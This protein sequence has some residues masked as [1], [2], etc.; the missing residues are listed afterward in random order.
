MSFRLD[1]SGVLRSKR[2]TVDGAVRYDAVLT[3]TGVFTYGD[4]KKTWREYR[5]PSEVFDAESMAS[6]G[7]VPVTDDHPP[8]FVTSDN[9]NTYKKGRVGEDI[10][11]DGNNMVGSLIVDDAG[12]LGKM[13]NG[14]EE[15]SNGYECVVVWEAGVSPEGEKYDARQ[16]QIRGN[17]VAV[18]DRGRAGNAKVRADA[19]SMRTDCALQVDEETA[20]GGM[21][22]NGARNDAPNAV[23]RK[24][25]AMNLEQALA[26]LAQANKDNGALGV[27]L[28][29]AKSDAVSAEQKAKDTATALVKAEAERDSAKSRADGAE[30]KV[31]DA[32]TAATKAKTDAAA[33]TSDQ[34]KA[35]VA[36]YTKAAAVGVKEIKRTVDGKET[37]IGLLD[38][39]PREVQLAVISKI[40]GAEVP[41][42]KRDNDAYVDA[43]F[44]F[45]IEAHRKS[46][47][48]FDQLNAIVNPAAKT[49]EIAPKPTPSGAPSITEAEAR[50]QMI[51]DSA[52][53]HKTTEGTK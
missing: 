34:V 11:R 20:T 14:K 52:N 22:P 10:K 51:A 13:A 43:R 27:Q 37:A 9:A 4:G 19:M 24:E 8:E 31:K 12:L 50:K 6:F 21:V 3:R 33:A 41:A 46:G 18:V 38:A 25:D 15:V 45:A 32:E 47:K 28:A 1:N 16:T 36:L 26:A 44:D 30:Q 2:V 35:R 7:L 40:D 53:A 39:E 29:A 42:E 49:T 48:A 17:H 23:Q 5:A